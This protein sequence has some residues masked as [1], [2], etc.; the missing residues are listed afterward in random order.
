MLP[1]KRAESSRHRRGLLLKLGRGADVRA[2]WKE[3]LAANPPKHDDWFGYA[4]LCLFLGDQAEY[5]RARR[6][7]LAQFGS[8][9]DPAVAER[10]ARA[11]LLLP[12]EE[13][14]LSQ[15]VALA[16]RAVAAGRAGHEFAY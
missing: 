8:A 12:A 5:R 11:C 7:L 16:G 9:T 14:E 4:E 15:A 10:T 13:L 6:E 2:A 1:E 3:E